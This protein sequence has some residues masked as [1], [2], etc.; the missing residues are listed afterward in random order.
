[1]HERGYSQT[2][3]GT[4]VHRELFH[5]SQIRVR[6]HRLRVPQRDTRLKCP[7]SFPPPRAL[8]SDFLCKDAGNGIKTFISRCQ[9]S[10]VSFSVGALREPTATHRCTQTNRRTG[11]NRGNKQNK[12]LIKSWRQMR[13]RT[14]GS[15]LLCKYFPRWT[16][17]TSSAKNC[18]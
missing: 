3:R 1:M 15:F 4:R 13:Q 6:V 9:Q 10:D 16:T 14:K 2:Q 11:G 12:H 7:G 18:F 17:Q 5:M 8:S